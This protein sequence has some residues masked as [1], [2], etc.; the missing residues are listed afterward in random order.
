MDATR[1]PGW[2]PAP[3]GRGEQWWNGAGWSESRKAV[4][5]AVAEPAAPPDP[6]IIYS[7]SNP[8]PQSP[9]ESPE[10]GGP[11]PAAVR[12]DA[13]ANPMAVYAL[14]AGIGAVIFNVLLVPSI[15]AIVFGAKGITRARELAAA[16]QPNTM[17]GLAMIGLA[18]GIFGGALSLISTVSFLW[19]VLASI[20]VSY[21]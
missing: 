1:S 17:R 2:Y 6:H 5:P 3:D 4:T 15:L 14:V 9:S 16:G 11:V 13:R 18:L 7:A 21:S 19:S 12:I 20:T 8:A 10:F